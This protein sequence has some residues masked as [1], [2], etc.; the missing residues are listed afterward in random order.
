LV[1]RV[2]K[3]EVYFW[4]N[5]SIL[6][7]TCSLYSLFCMWVQRVRLKRSLLVSRRF[8]FPEPAAESV[9]I[10]VT[11]PPTCGRDTEVS[12]L[13]CNPRRPPRRFICLSPIPRRPRTAPL[14]LGF[15]AS[16]DHHSFH[17]DH[18]RLSWLAHTFFVD[19]V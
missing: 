1:D 17:L 3:T 7:S 16:A 18:G 14:G 5:P 19:R 12:P 10:F 6:K 9:Y 4:P 11:T 15:P 13:A 2:N 8:Y